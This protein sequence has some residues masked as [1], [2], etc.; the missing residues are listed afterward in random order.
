MLKLIKKNVILV[1]KTAK[2][3]QPKQTAQNVLTL[4]IY[5]LSKILALHVQ[6]NVLLNIM[7]TKRINNVFLAQTKTVNFVQIIKIVKLVM[8]ITIYY[9]IAVYN[10]LQTVKCVKAA[11]FVLSVNKDNIFSKTNAFKH[12]LILINMLI[13]RPIHV[14]YVIVK[15]R[16][17]KLNQ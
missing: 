3:V 9:K 1:Q 8:I 14:F 15:S 12:A 5:Y 10:V 2:H 6:P 13:Q 17:A 16:D 7:L 4:I 11:T